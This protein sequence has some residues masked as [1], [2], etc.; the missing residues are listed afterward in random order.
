MERIW[1]AVSVAEVTEHRKGGWGI[2]RIALVSVLAVIG[3]LAFAPGARAITPTIVNGASGNNWLESL[4]I[5]GEDTGN[6]MHV[7]LVVKHDPDLAVTGVWMDTNFNNVPDTLVNTTAEQPSGDFNYSRVS[8]SRSVSYGSFRCVDIFNGPL[9]RTSANVAVRARLSNGTETSQVSTSAFTIADGQCTGADDFPFLFNQSQ[10]A[11]NLNT[12]QSVTF[13]FRGDDP[14][15]TGSGNQF[16]G[17]AWRWRRLS[18]GFTTSEDLD[19]YGNADNSD[20]TLTATPPGRGR[21][22]MEAEA[23]NADSSCTMNPNDNR[24][25]RLGAVN[26]NAPASSSPAGSISGVPARPQIN[27][28]FT[29]TANVEDSDDASNGGKVQ[30][31]EWDADGN[32]LYERRELGDNELATPL[33]TAQRQQSINTTGKAPGT[34][35]VRAQIFDNGAI[36]GADSIRRSN[37]ITATYTVDSPPVANNTN[38]LTETNQAVGIVLGGPSGATDANNDPLTY[39]VTDPPDNGTLS[40]NGANQTYTPSN[41]FAGNDSFT[42]QVAD[43]F[44]GTDTA[45]VSI[46]VEPNTNATGPSGTVNSRGADIGYSSDATGASFECSL[47]NATFAPC[48]TSPRE[49]RDLADGNHNVRV[50]AVVGSANDST[51]AGISW[52]IDAFPAIDITSGPDS[53]TDEIDATFAFITSE[54]GATVDP[55]THCQLDGGDFRPCASPETYTDVDDGNHTLVVRATDAYGKTAT[56]S[57]SWSVDAVGSNT[58]ISATPNQRLSNQ[59]DY[60]FDLSSPDPD[61][62]FQCRLPGSADFDPCTSPQA[63]SRPEGTYTIRARAVDAVGNVDPTPAS[64]TWR[65]DQTDPVASIDRGPPDPTNDKTPTF[66]FSANERASFECRVNDGTDPAF[67]ACTSPFTSSELAD[68]DYTFQVQA[69]DA[70]NNLADPVSFGPFTV[71][72]LAPTTQITSGPTEGSAVASTT[73]EFA[74]DSPSDAGAAFQCRIDSGLWSRCTSPKSYEGLTDGPHTFSVRAVD[75]AE[76]VDEAPPARTWSIDSTPP[77]TSIT[78]GPSG[79]VRASESSFEFS[80]EPAGADFECRLDS[81]DPSDFAPCTSPYA[82]G[83]LA[84]GE[85]TFDVRSLDQLDNTDLTP[86]SRT[87]VIDT[88]PLPPPNEPPPPPQEE[89]CTF[90]NRDEDCGRPYLEADVRSSEPRPDR[91]RNSPAV[92]LVADG[93]GAELRRAIF[94]IPD[95]L[96]VRPLSY[97]RGR[98]VGYIELYRPGQRKRT[99]GLFLEG[100]TPFVLSDGDP[101]VAISP[102]SKRI[103]ITDVPDDVTL[104]R[105]H[106]KGST[107]L[108]TAV[109]RCVSVRWH[110]SLTDNAGNTVRQV[111]VTDSTCV[112]RSNR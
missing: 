105:L 98:R 43:G 77:Q 108:I 36:N 24:Y 83:P 3:C 80:A 29:A 19:C 4:S 42:F 106:L 82:T 95:A 51:P 85:H 6:V 109:R 50:R 53:E 67:S 38:F 15:A 55:V 7:T 34:Y 28:S 13:S 93:G 9:R 111:T 58:L 47:D 73:A 70:A 71:D 81:T 94:R 64:F 91:R 110:A 32:N 59:S 86:A 5:P 37:V 100:S 14:D 33:T 20:R 69:T 84:D 21:W 90:E 11:T 25:F 102:G 1:P 57:W 52:S 2:P 45:T 76:N 99:I 87:W 41:G 31:L 101:R 35:T 74:F 63:V 54:A 72:T 97:F 17:I 96:A 112:R 60:T 22:V 89:P 103:R 75:E 61:A 12:G 44:G 10:N 62:V 79:T 23:R 46:R 48:G 8:V 18:D 68:G 27:Q 40:G 78:R 88:S 56:D 104:I 39:T 30:W 107:G 92:D 49:Y 16:G 26:V 65:I 66:E